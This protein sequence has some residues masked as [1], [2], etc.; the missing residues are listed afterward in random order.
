M[1]EL[2]RP[3]PG[4]PG[5]SA[6]ATLSFDAS[7]RDILGPLTRGAR[8]VMVPADEAAE[9]ARL[10]ARMREHGVTAVMS[11]VPSRLGPLL[12]AAEGGDAGVPLRLLL[13]SGEALPAEAGRRAPASAGAE[14]G[15][16]G[17]EGVVG[18]EQGLVD[19]SVGVR[20]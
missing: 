19:V 11:I 2:Q 6:R 13:T 8:L 18:G 15:A 1:D 7:I 9:P 10:L 12:D 16:D 3:R 4:S 17:G 14:G 5:G 20:R